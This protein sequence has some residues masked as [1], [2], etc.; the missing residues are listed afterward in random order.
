MISSRGRSAGSGGSGCRVSVGED[1]VLK[2]QSKST[3]VMNE[4]GC[5]FISSDEIV[6]VFKGEKC[7]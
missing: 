7:Q 2:K 1:S 3:S 6:N 4:N 5:W